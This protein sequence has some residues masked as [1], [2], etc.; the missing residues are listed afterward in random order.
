MIKINQKPIISHLIEKFKIH[1]FKNF[2]FCV[3]YK[4]LIIKRYFK[5]GK[6]FDINIEYSPENSFLGTAGLFL[7]AKKN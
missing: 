5:D 6:N 3:N 7:N 4:S 1:G 2:I